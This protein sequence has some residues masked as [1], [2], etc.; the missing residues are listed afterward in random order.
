MLVDK[1]G[2]PRPKLIDKDGDNKTQ[3]SLWTVCVFQALSTAFRG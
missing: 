3:Q 1:V 2:D